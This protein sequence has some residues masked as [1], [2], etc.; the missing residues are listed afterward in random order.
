MTRQTNRRTFLQSSLPLGAGLLVLGDSRLAFGAEANDRLNIA[1][2]GVAGMGAG[3]VNNLSSQNIVA[4]CDVH[5]SRAAKTYEKHPEA[6]VYTDF[7]RMLDELDSQI[8]AVVVSTPDHTHAVS[9]VA[10]M[11]RGKH[12]YCEK[13]L[14]R[15]V[16]EARVMR[17]TAVRYG[18]VTQMGNQGSASE[19]L[20]RAVELAWAGTV[21]PVQ[22]AHL[23]FGGGDGPRQRPADEPPVPPDLQWD[24]WLGPAPYRPYHPCYC[25]AT[26]RGWR[27]FGSGGMGDMGCHTAN[28]L[29]RSLHLDRLWNLEPGSPKPERV[30]LRFDG[31]AS[32]VDVEGYPRWMV[33]DIDIP[34]RGELPPVKLTLYTGGRHPSEEVMRGDEMTKWG[35][36]LDGPRGALFTDCPWNTRYALLPKAEFEGFQ[37]PERTLPR[38]AGHHLEWIEACKGRG[39]TFSSFSIGGPLTECIQLANVAATVREPFEYDTLSG[40]VLN[41]PAA[42]ELLHREYR[43]GW[44]L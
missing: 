27:D 11:K 44:T 17:E 42:N 20:R 28:M 8:D 19:G 9:A 31:E 7:R 3:N 22:R 21:G 6:K 33:V 39:E 40:Q 35:A 38:I 4:L 43:E 15:T 12:V 37:G 36:L 41:H 10:A 23:W 14:T 5:E 25:P 32:E 18:V 30:M 13:P 26:W 1:A 2:V 24:L 34:A 16:Y 29:F